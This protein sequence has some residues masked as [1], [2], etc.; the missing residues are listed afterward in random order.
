MV[1]DA[2]VPTQKEIYAYIKIES[3]CAK[4]AT[5]IFNAF[6]EVYPLSAF[7]FSTTCR[8]VRDF[9]NGW[10]ESYKKPSSGRV[11]TGTD[12]DNTKIVA[13]LLNSDRRFTYKEI[14]YKW[15]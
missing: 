5:D 4:K 14:A 12:D 1:S 9:N 15:G 8:W 10:Q 11:V 3:K 6:Q 13:H 7:G 2:F